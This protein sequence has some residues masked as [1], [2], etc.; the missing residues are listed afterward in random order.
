MNQGIERDHIRGRGE[1]FVK[2]PRPPPEDVKNKVS[3]EKSAKSPV[4]Y[5]LPLVMRNGDECGFL[6]VD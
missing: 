1:D 6:A 2:E 3:G 5:S 4:A